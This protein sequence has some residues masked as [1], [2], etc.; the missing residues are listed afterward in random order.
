MTTGLDTHTRRPPRRSRVL[1]VAL[2]TALPLSVCAF[3]GSAE[4]ATCTFTGSTDNQWNDATNW[5]NCGGVVPTAA[6]D[7]TSLGGKNP[8]LTTGADGVANSISFGDT[9]NFRVGAGKTMTVGAGAS[10]IVSPQVIVDGGATLR[11]NGT[12]TWSGGTWFTG[13][14][15]TSGTIEN[16]GTLIIP[17]DVNTAGEPSGVLHNLAG[18]TLNRTNSAGTATFGRP[19]DNDGTVNVTSGTLALHDGS[20]AGNTS[21]GSFTAGAGSTVS[22]AGLHSLGA[23]ASIDGAGTA[24][25]GSGGGGNVT[26]LAAGAAYSPGTTAIEGGFVDLAGNGTTGRI[27]QNG[28]GGGR[29]GAGQLAVGSGASNFDEVITFRGGGLTSFAAGATT[30]I[31]GTPGAQFIVEG[32]AT[33]RLN[34]TTTWSGGTMLAGNTGSGT[35]ENAGTLNVTG[36]VIGGGIPAGL[37]HN[38]AGATLNR[39]TS[40][41]TATFATPFDNDGAVN[42]T[43]G[44]LALH[45]GSGVGNTSAGSFTPSAGT[46]ISFGGLHSLGAGASIDGAGT[47]RFASTSGSSVTALAAGAA[48]S[49]ATTAAEGGTVSL[50][51]DGTTGRITSNGSGGGRSGAGRLDV[52][53][54]ASSFNQITFGGGLTSF[55][56]GGTTAGVA[57]Q[58]I[59]EGGATLR[60]N[61]TTTWSDGTWFAGNTGGGTIE[62]AGTLD[63]PSDVTL[64]GSGPGGL[65]NLP[66]ASINRTTSAGTTLLAG[67]F[68][69]DG[70]V[71]VASGRL[72]APNYTQT[73]G[74]TT[75]ATGAT[76]GAGG[77]PVAL[78]GGVLSGGGTVNGN[79]DNT[80][81]SVSPG[82]SPG[83]LTIDGNYTQGSG[84]T[85]AA[86]IAGTTPG[87]QFDVLAVTGSAALD[88]TLAISNDPGFDPQLSDTFEVLTAT[89]R[90]GT[91]AQLTGASVGA[92]TYE[93][94]YNPGD[95]T[96]AVTAVPP[97]ATPTITD[98]DPDSPSANNNPTFNGT[99]DPNTTIRLY[100]NAGC[101][102]QIGQGTAAEFT[103]AVDGT[104]VGLSAPVADNSTTQ[105]RATATDGADNTSGCSTPFA[106]VEDS[107]PPAAPII[108][109]ITDSDPD[110]PSANNNPTFNG[111]TDP[112]TTIRLYSNA[113]CTT[114]IGQGTAAEFTSA[115]DGTGVGLSAP[116]ADNSTTQV[117]ATATDGASNT[118]GCS[119]PFAYVEESPSAATASADLALVKTASAEG[120]NPGLDLTYTLAITNQGPDEAEGVVVRDPLPAGV[121]LVATKASQGI[122]SGEATVSC[123]LGALVGGATSKVEIVVSPTGQAG[124][125]LTNTATVAAITSDP[126]RADNTSTVTT[127]LGRGE[128]SCPGIT[129]DGL[130]IEGT[131]AGDTLV[132]S[133]RSDEI[134]GAAGRD[135]I[136][137]DGGADCLIG[138]GGGDKI[139][140]GRGNDAIRGGQGGDK[141]DG[142]AGNDD[143]RAQN[144]R[145]EVSGG[146]GD[147]AIN[148]RDGRRDKVKCGPG[149]DSVVGDAR[150]K[151]SPNCEQVRIV[152]EA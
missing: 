113:G 88:G 51:G 61:G 127:E 110:S 9:I 96:L 100:S 90:S 89:S 128:S 17:G 29:G 97:P 72:N 63:I 3:A 144:G 52:G 18:A 43:S 131:K 22:F 141:I 4:A 118:S 50:A 86:E 147:D 115:V 69:N 132:G 95:V 11:L 121:E 108:P 71:T 25:F 46:T 150:D 32:G 75:V 44:T 48:Y 125:S 20:G 133:V 140:G 56:P 6:D 30:T 130:R 148:A 74:T 104:G 13:D 91:F 41:A 85:L 28:G 149:D 116:V 19:F 94:D 53:S 112:N 23:G 14:S 107:P 37:F 64:G 34:G 117:R 47:A 27:T 105:V 137:G 60:L 79:V 65:H 36:D 122:C 84:G 83:T 38:M 45:G 62:N 21:T 101:T 78:Q 54:G 109:T 81:G 57:N 129:I 98:S 80:G 2:L 10:L 15:G 39:T 134:R 142:G 67:P 70:A 24:R 5:S 106:Y 26:S 77:A 87:T 31:A 1:L 66:G 102:T 119:A 82:S 139:K 135:A 76:L 114:Q 111:T 136:Q 8:S 33:L 151:I 59:V 99:T 124:S 7:V 93:A 49:P 145:D 55:A 58:M 143:V 68:Q 126:N 123:E 35:I 103:S 73:A 138:Q 92:K 120:T 146:S 42:V 16:A 40:A 12:T 152:R